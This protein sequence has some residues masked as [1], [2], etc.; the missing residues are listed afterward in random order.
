MKSPKRPRVK[1]IHSWK[2]A[3]GLFEK[4]R[5]SCASVKVELRR[6]RVIDAVPI[7]FLRGEPAEGTATQGTR[8][9]RGQLIYHTAAD[10]TIRRPSGA[11]LIIDNY[12]IAAL[13]DSRS[14][15]EPAG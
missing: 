2:Q 3:R 7:D 5:K 4:W 11:I 10:V 12:E 6:P 8:V 15:F 9:F 1:T 14:R 13:S